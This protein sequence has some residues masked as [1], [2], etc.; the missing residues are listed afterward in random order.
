MLITLAL[1]L[2]GCASEDDSPAKSPAGESPETS[3]PPVT[4]P[5]PTPTPTE[6]PTTTPATLTDRLLPTDA[7]PGLN[8]SWRWQDGETGPA[9]SEPFGRCAKVDL[10]SIGATEV[11]ERTYFPPVDTDDNAAEQIAEF[12]DAT[13]TATALKVLKSWH[14]RCGTKTVKAGTLTTVDGGSWYLL[15]VSAAHADEGLFQAVGL[16]TSGT[17]IAVLTMDSIGQDYN[18]PAGKEPMVAMVKAAAVRLG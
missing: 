1:G 11:V 10:V 4:T 17:R 14:K 15:T 18:Y 16:V 12:P 13:T 3:A 7:V 6:T 5:D 8:A 9:D 2:G